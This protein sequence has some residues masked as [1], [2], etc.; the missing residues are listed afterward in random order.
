[1]V[2]GSDTDIDLL[3]TPKNAG[4]VSFGTYTGTI[5][6]IAG[7]IEIKDSGGTVRKLAVVA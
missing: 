2:G 1:M 4:K 7:Y 5:L 6:V 3:L